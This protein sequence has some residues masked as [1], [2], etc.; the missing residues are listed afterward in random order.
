[1]FD[2]PTTKGYLPNRDRSDTDPSR[3][4]RSVTVSRPVSFRPPAS[5]GRVLSHLGRDDVEAGLA[6]AD[7]PHRH[8]L[9]AFGLPLRGYGPPVILRPHAVLSLLQIELRQQDHQAGRRRRIYRRSRSSALR[10][11]AR[12]WTYGRDLERCPPCW[13]SPVQGWRSRTTVGTTSG[14][15]RFDQRPRGG[16]TLQGLVWPRGVSGIAPRGLPITSAAVVN[17]SS[18]PNRNAHFV[19]GLITAPGFARARHGHRRIDPA[20][21]SWPCLC[22]F[23]RGGLTFLRRLPGFWF[24]RCC[25]IWST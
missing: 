12:C 14:I 21:H 16:T 20:C 25:R 19:A 2:R 9:A 24:R 13:N 15:G 18:P 8:R 6:R 7:H 23:G 11:D 22:I 3:D 10:K 1:M 17:W 4:R 5:A